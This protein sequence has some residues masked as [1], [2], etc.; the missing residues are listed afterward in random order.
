[1]A[2]M[3]AQSIG[4]KC[5]FHIILHLASPNGTL[6]ARYTKIMLAFGLSGLVHYFIAIATGIPLSQ[7]GAFKFFVMQ[8]LGIMFEDALQALYR[9]HRSEKAWILDSNR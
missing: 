1:M 3:V 8:G 6:F 9:R 7:T 2:S 5:D 4:R